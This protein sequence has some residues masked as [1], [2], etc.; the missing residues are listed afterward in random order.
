MNCN[1]TGKDAVEDGPGL[2]LSLF[3]NCVSVLANPLH[4]FAIMALVRKLLWET[5]SIQFNIVYP[6]LRTVCSS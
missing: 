5:I 6:V 4:L 1:G 2:L 3:C